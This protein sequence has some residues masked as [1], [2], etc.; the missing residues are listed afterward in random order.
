MPVLKVK[1]NGVWEQFTVPG[2]THQEVED[3]KALVGEAS[4]AEQINSAIS[5]T[6]DAESESA[7][8][9][10]AVAEALSTVASQG[11]VQSDWNETD[12]TSLAFIKNKPTISADGSLPVPQTA[13]IGQYLQVSEVDENGAITGMAA[14]DTAASD[15]ETMQN[16]PFGETLLITNILT[17]QDLEFADVGNGMYSAEFPS[18][19]TYVLGQ[20]YIVSWG[21]VEYECIAANMEGGSNYIGSLAVA[22]AGDDTGEPFLSDGNMIAT[23]ETDAA[24]TV[25]IKEKV[26]NVKTIDSK[27]LPDNIGGDVLPEVTADDNGMVLGVADGIWQKITMSASSGTSA[28]ADWN[29]NDSSQSDYIK[30]RPF[31]EYEDQVELLPITTY[32]DFTLNSVFGVYGVNSTASYTLVIG[33]KYTVNW[34]GVEYECIAKD[35]G[36]VL[37]GSVF[38][39]DAAS[40]G[41]EGNDEPFIIGYANGGVSYFSL[42]DTEAGGSHTVGI[43]Q[44]RIIVNQIDKKYL[45]ILSRTGALFDNVVHFSLN[46]EGTGW[47]SSTFLYDASSAT[48]VNGETYCVVWND[49]EYIC[50]CSILEGMPAIGN[51]ELLFNLGD[52]GMPFVIIRDFDGA[53][54]GSPAWLL[55]SIELTMNPADTSLS[56]TYSCQVKNQHD[57]Y[58]NHKYLD[59]MD[60]WD[61]KALITDQI[62][63]FTLEYE[64][65]THPEESVFMYMNTD[66]IYQSL[67][68]INAGRS[69]AITL[70]GCVFHSDAVDVSNLC[71][72]SATVYKAVALG[73]LSLLNFGE[74]T[75]E[76]FA[77]AV[78]DIY[79]GG[80]YESFALFLSKTS[81][82]PTSFDTL[83]SVRQKPGGMIKK[84]WLPSDLA[85]TID[86]SNV[87]PEVTTNDNN[88][89]MTVVDGVW[90]AQTPASS[91]PT[92]TTSDVGKFLRVSSDGLWIAEAVPNAEEASF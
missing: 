39:G 82:N 83:I 54:L 3:I 23:R 44:T 19:H 56:G 31:Y 71:G 1:N 30:N 69:Y 7:M 66:T 34:D 32:T 64:N 6:Y 48:L 65:T 70:D 21:G 29:Q 20:T 57:H 51:I 76:L 14:V 78:M 27:Y 43:S 67:Y 53:A 41:L 52:N 36:S 49:I 9:G 61:A 81:P 73:N 45:P 50:E 86:A 12:E 2:H 74:D 25:S 58:V 26:A 84:E 18:S 13:S 37:P 63:T 85:G 55:M 72:S 46:S 17:E 5:D 80:T 10:R 8:S 59:F 87:L 22:G 91:L 60:S 15:W 89:V 92:V 38:L 28:K 24:H 47:E 42:A 90:T 62:I 68:A 40:F 11:C 75:G 33:E 35:G 88:K 16:R 79:S 4:V 77:I